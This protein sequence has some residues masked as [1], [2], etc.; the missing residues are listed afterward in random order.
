MRPVEH[1]GSKSLFQI[2]RL[3][4]A[5]IAVLGLYARHGMLLGR[6]TNNL[7]DAWLHVA[8]AITFL[9]SGLAPTREPAAL[10]VI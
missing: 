9:I 10:P 5:L 6:I 8:V 1:L 7:A 2:L 4:Y 3:L